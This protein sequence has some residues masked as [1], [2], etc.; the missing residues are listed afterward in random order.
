MTADGLRALYQQ[1]ILDHARSPRNVRIPA[2]ATCSAHG[3]NP[4]CGDRI[5]VHLR[6]REDGVIGDAGFQGKGCALA[7]ASASLMTELAPG[8]TSAEAQHLAAAVDRLCRGG[9]VDRGHDEGR[10]AGLV[11]RLEVFSG[12]RGF[13]ARAGCVTLAWLS[14]VAALQGRDEASSE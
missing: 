7:L 5:S 2:D 6:V 4:M 1:T 12:V 14:M 11:E 10:I 9:T 13:P 8:L 3:H